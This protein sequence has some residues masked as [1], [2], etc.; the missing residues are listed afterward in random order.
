MTRMPTRSFQDLPSPAGPRVGA[1][2]LFVVT[3]LACLAQAASWAFAAG[4]ASTLQGHDLNITIDTQWAGNTHG[5]YY[6]VRTR[7]VNRG[8]SRVLTFMVSSRYD[9]MPTVRR[10]MQVPQNATVQFTLSVPMVSPSCN[11]LFE[12]YQDG[13]LLEGL[14]NNL[15]L[16]DTEHG[17]P[18]RPALLVI[19][20]TNVD[21]DRFE[22][23]V[24]A[25]TGAGAAG[26][27][28]AH[29]ASGQSDNHAIVPP[30]MLPES[31]IDY[32]GLDIVAV[33]L[34]TLSAMPRENRS[35]ILKWVHTGGTLIVYGVKQKAAT[36]QPLLHALELDRQGA[37]EMDWEPCDPR[38]RRVIHVPQTDEHGR[39]VPELATPKT[40]EPETA[41]ADSNPFTK[42]FKAAEGNQSRTARPFQ[43]SGDSGT[44]V[45][46]RLV[47]GYV[48]AFRDNPF[49]GSPHDWAWF[50]QS[51]GPERYR[52]ASRHGI[53]AR[54]ES[55]DFLQ[56][57]IPGIQGVPVFSF[58]ALITVFAVVIGPL[59]YWFLWKQKR[60][61]LLIVSIP[62]IALVTS[63]TLLAYSVIAHGFA[64]KS[65]TRSF[66]VLDQN[67]KTA[68]T[69]SRIALFAGLAPSRGLRFSPDTAV[70]TIWSTYQG[71][72]S[73]SVD[74]T[75]TQA[76]THGWLRSRTRT[77]FLTVSHR[78]ER[79]RLEIKA[80]EADRLPMSNGFEWGIEALVVSNASG[81]LFFGRDIPAGAAALLTPPTKEDRAA[82]IALLDRHPLQAPEGVQAASSFAAY[83]GRR[84]G[85]RR[86]YRYGTSPSSPAHWT[87]GFMERSIAGLKTVLVA[88][89]T[90]S[91]L[92]PRSYLAV[93][94]QSPAVELGVE[95]TEEQV[96]WHVLVGYF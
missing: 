86:R 7:V 57:R 79:G 1:P 9:R 92:P 50:L 93:L 13:E 42:A 89:G 77:Q 58:L 27:H 29:Y 33:S 18:E 34:D 94:K 44:F 23:A 91:S 38:T 71:F 68:V 67:S 24:T 84:Y 82:V 40:A 28:G 2:W 11:G 39:L 51:V 64:I 56:F 60:L 30:V 55:D 47:L 83:G 54:Q 14:R 63:V 88:A 52:W 16:P 53:S 61:H 78:A 49:P 45:R 66:T 12:V 41:E 65:R 4:N 25:A 69:A 5:G 6:P 62:V 32:S 21:C 80:I 22:D 26:R 37:P 43:W 17:S 8:A 19:S 46:R 70:H 87:Q 74:W 3:L 10:T 20:P 90:H 35:A 96:G 59:N 81:D 72:E 15:N 76:L 36:S 73:G 31:W 85:R 95:H 75:E 48:Y